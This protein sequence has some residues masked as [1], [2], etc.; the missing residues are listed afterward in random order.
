MWFPIFGDFYCEDYNE[1]QDNGH[2][3]VKY[4]DGSND[5]NL[6]HSG[7]QVEKRVDC[8]SYWIKNDFIESSPENYYGKAN[9]KRHSKETLVYACGAA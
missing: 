9:V 5:L 4:R 6:I 3:R 7:E 2:N 8:D 1:N